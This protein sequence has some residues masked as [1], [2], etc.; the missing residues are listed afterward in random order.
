[1]EKKLNMKTNLNKGEGFFLLN[2]STLCTNKIENSKP[3]R[4]VHI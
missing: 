2:G 1:M 4:I 3:L